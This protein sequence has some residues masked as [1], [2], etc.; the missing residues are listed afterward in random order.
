MTDTHVTL[1]HRIA[2]SLAEMLRVRRVVPALVVL[3]VGILLAVYFHF[4]QRRR[5]EQEQV[6]RF[7]KQALQ[8]TVRLHSAFQVPLEVLH[9]VPA[10]FNASEEVSRREFAAFVRRSLER[11]PEIYALEWFPRVSSAERAQTEAVAKSQ[12]WPSFQFSE[13]GPRG[14]MVPAAERSVY[15]PLYYMEPPNSVA[16]GFD[17]ASD[18]DRLAPLLKARDSGESVV[19]GRIRLVEDPPLVYSVAVFSPVYRTSRTPE[20]Q[21]QRRR[22]FRGAAAL[23]LRVA[24][25]VEA[26]LAE[27]D[28]DHAA[29]VLRDLDAPAERE[30][31]YESRPGLAREFAAES[32]AR[33]QS[34]SKLDLLG[35]RWQVDLRAPAPPTSYGQLGVGLSLSLLLGLM[36]FGASGFQQLRQRMHRAM[37]LGQYTLEEKIGEGGMAVV[38][39]GHHALLSRPTAIKLLSPQVGETRLKRFEREVELTSNLTHPNTIVVYDYGRTQDGTLYYVMEYLDGVTFDELSRFEGALPPS[40]VRYLLLQICGA[41]REAHSVGL[42]HRDVKPA[43]LMLTCRGQLADF[44]KVLD[45]GLVKQISEPEAVG[46]S[47]VQTILGTPGFLSPESILSPDQVDARSDLYSLGAVAY[48]LLTGQPVFAGNSVVEICVQ[49]INDPPV[50]PSRRLGRSISPELEK[51]VLKC[52]TKEPERRFQSADELEAALLECDDLSDWSQAEAHLWWR[53]WNE[54]RSHVRSQASGSWHGTVAV[55]LDRRAG[56]RRPSGFGA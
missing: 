52:L 20:S 48:L 2:P 25:V 35:R 44:V 23:V 7:T 39:R 21:E 31:L 8:T 41:L 16:L 27:L 1:K 12:G 33:L 37:K 56:R 36:T 53:E 9:S 51:I 54:G 40:R 55:D 24:P 50:L 17:L 47:G 28:Y 15:F 6:V 32:A 30:L 22:A 14:A 42:I 34:T 46:L 4:E 45:F 13:V 38:Y 43:N 29:F 49:H 18:A 19:S 11:R 5:T 3:F 26:A 10:L